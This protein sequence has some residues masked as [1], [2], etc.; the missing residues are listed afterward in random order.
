[1]LTQ[2][3]AKALVRCSG[4]SSPKESVSQTYKRSG[5]LGEDTAAVSHLGVG[6]GVVDGDGV[7]L[8]LGE[9]L[10]GVDGGG[11]F[12]ACHGRTLVPPLLCVQH[13][14]RCCCIHSICPG[15]Q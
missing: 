11:D 3:W 5:G 14:A 2:P 7:V 15:K 10:G 6:D 12:P 4:G 8:G 13:N 9:V 1:M